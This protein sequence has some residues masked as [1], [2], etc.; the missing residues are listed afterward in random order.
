MTEPDEF[1]VDT[2]RSPFYEWLDHAAIRDLVHRA[3]ALPV[4]E[5]LTLLKGLIPSLVDDL[6]EIAVEQ[7]LDELGTKAHRYR[8]ALTH[9]G[10]GGAM[11]ETRG[12]TLGGPTP[13]GEMHVDVARDPRR[14]GG[15]A[16]ERKAEAELW[17][18]RE[19]E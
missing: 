7:F 11:R 6:G 18:S 5:R 16:L 2:T 1:Q 19:K 13:D 4:G 3:I 8:E 14:P 12:E 15:R 10:I 9:R 17:A